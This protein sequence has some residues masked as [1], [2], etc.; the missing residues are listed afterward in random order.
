MDVEPSMKRVAVLPWPD[1]Q[2]C[3]L[4]LSGKRRSQEPYGH[5]WYAGHEERVQKWHDEHFR[6]EPAIT[7]TY[8]EGGIAAEWDGDSGPIQLWFKSHDGYKEGYDEAQPHW[9]WPFAFGAGHWSQ[10]AVRENNLPERFNE[11]D[12]AAIFSVLRHWVQSRL[13]EQQP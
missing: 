1:M 10:M 5:R 2:H 9:L 7:F 12:Y 13:K 3:Y 4:V 6:S 8:A 11:G